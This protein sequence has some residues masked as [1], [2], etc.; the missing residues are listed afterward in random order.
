M[1]HI[2]DTY[3]NNECLSFYSHYNLYSIFISTV[4]RTYKKNRHTNAFIFDRTSD[5]DYNYNKK[6]E[7]AKTKKEILI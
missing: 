6:R 1:V 4:Q 7:K 5:L 2:N 3:S